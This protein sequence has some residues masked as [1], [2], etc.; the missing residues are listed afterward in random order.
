M[1]NIKKLIGGCALAL[2][3]C[4][5]GDEALLLTTGDV[6]EYT[7]TTADTEYGLTE[8]GG[9]NLDAAMDANPTT[10]A[11]DGT[12][13]VAIY[14][15]GAV[16]NPGVYYVSETAIKET[17]VTMAGGFLEEADETYV[18][19]AQ[20]VTGGEQI[21]IPTRDETVGLSLSSRETVDSQKTD[22]AEEIDAK[23]NINTAG[24]EQLMTL[25]GIG[26]SK[27]DAI[28]AYRESQ[29]RFQSTDELMNIQGI[30]EGIYNKIKDLIIVG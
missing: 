28:I 1:H 24:K 13:M 6:E 23:I 30:K 19:L 18:N 10:E 3:L 9:Q 14:V 2:M 12:Q 8:N 7:A 5:C 11:A 4:G 26:E 16:R 27:A 22:D 25:P 20:T 17:V 29:G 15:C 21:Y